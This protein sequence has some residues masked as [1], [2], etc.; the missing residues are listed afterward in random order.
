MCVL[1]GLPTTLSKHATYFP[2]GIWF[3]DANTLYVADEGN[4]DNTYSNGL[5][6]V[7]AGQTTAG[8]Q[9]WIF[10][11]TSGQWNLA[12]VLQS[13]LQLGVPYTVGAIRTGITRPRTCRGLPEPTV[14][15]TSPVS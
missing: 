3:A 7:A 11:S 12:Y 4:G 10:D 6:T 8:L 9:K 5:Y 15:G 13:G 2:F 14:C 1:N